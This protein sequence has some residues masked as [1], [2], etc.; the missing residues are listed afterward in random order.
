MQK[1]IAFFD[2]DGTITRKDTMLELARF[3]TGSVS[4]YFGLCIL[5]P[6][7]VA[8]KLG[9]VTKKKAKEKLLTH[10]FG[11]TPLDFFNEKCISFNEQVITR[12]IKKDAMV[13]IQN[14]LAENTPVV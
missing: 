11:E 3:S 2:F 6:W 7:L 14:H 12:L 5:S 4:Y 8:M 1:K 13:A 9:F 10:F